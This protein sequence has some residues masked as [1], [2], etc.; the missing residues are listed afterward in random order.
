M[1]FGGVGSSIQTTVSD[2]TKNKLIIVV[3]GGVERERRRRRKG[4]E[5][6]RERENGGVPL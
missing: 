3:G 6:E 2:F 5:R 4:G 1:T